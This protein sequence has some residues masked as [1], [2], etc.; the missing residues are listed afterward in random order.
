V[1]KPIEYLLR[2]MEE[3][4]EGDFSVR[5]NVKSK[6]ELGSLGKGFNVMLESVGTFISNI[7][8]VSG[9][10][11]ES[12]HS[13]AA[14]AEETSASA[15]QMNIAVEEIA[16]G[17]TE[18]ASDA[19]RGDQLTYNLSAKLDELADNTK[20]VEESTN[21]V[22]EANSEGIKVVGEL[23]SKTNS[24]E[25]AIEKIE[26]AVVELNTNTMSID[27]ILDTINSISEQTNLLA[28][29]ASIEA[30][31]AG[32]A[33]KG[34]AVVAD[35]IRKL[36]ES[37]KVATDEI[38]QII[39]KVQEDS[40][41]TVIRM[42]EV[43]SIAGEQ[44]AAVYEVNGTFQRISKSVEE[45]ISKI[46]F[47]SDSV[48]EI[49]NDKEE[50]VSSI[51]NISSISQETAAGA[52]EVTASIEQQSLTVQEVANSAD[53]LSDLVNKMNYELGKFRV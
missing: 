33:G 52:E 9:E 35:E 36:A 43:K 28:L 19:Q 21:E 8:N 1:T 23:K 41:N 3:V 22:T 34:F 17:A 20:K 13:L 50:I 49:N 29:N 46:E 2:V 44:S 15:E 51:Q 47:I 37:S 11:N 14:T 48:K 26:A 32:E 18:Q 4:K 25:K 27:S 38:K 39:F 5:S 30:A 7:K 42:N 24:N 12:S 31:R 10:V 6:D 53:K 40:N 16:R 45:I